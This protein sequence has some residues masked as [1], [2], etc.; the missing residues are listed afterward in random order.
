ME[1]SEATLLCCIV[2][3]RS[4]IHCYVGSNPR[5]SVA[6]TVDSRNNQLCSIL[7]HE[8]DQSAIAMAK[9]PQFHGRAKHID[10]R[11]HYVREQVSKGVVT[12]QYCPREDMVADIF[13]K[14][15]GNYPFLKLR[16]QSG[17]V[18]SNV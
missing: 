13:T 2:D 8:D 10:I 1:E 9:N 14:G 12:L 18:N 16:F 7:L 15:L 3:G 11:H 17:L 6:E 5:S 4:R